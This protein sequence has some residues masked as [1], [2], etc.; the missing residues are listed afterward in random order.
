MNNET[1][2]ESAISMTNK[3]MEVIK[4]SLPEIKAVI[5]R[6]NDF[7]WLDLFM[8]GIEEN[9]ST[10]KASEG[11]QCS[12]TATF[13]EVELKRRAESFFN[14]HKDIPIYDLKTQ[15]IDLLTPY[16]EMMQEKCRQSEIADYNERGVKEIFENIDSAIVEMMNEQYTESLDRIKA[17]LTVNALYCYRSYRLD[18]NLSDKELAYISFWFFKK[19]YALTLENSEILSPILENV[20]CRRETTVEYEKQSRVFAAVYE[21]LT[22][23]AKKAKDYEARETA[24]SLIK[25]RQILDKRHDRYTESLTEPQAEAIIAALEKCKEDLE[26][27]IAYQEL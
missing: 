21:A 2:L 26:L 19:E 20:F 13:N 3:P 9:L 17:A 10:I 5:D 11:D 23:M 24:K 15:F 25:A 1:N 18:K 7:E 12:I 4:I 6:M 8:T 14:E 22:I 27:E 16:L